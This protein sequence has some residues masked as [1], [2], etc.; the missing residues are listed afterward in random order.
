[1]DIDERLLAEFGLLHSYSTDVIYRLRYDNMSYEYISSSATKLLGFDPHE[2]QDVGIRSLI[3]QTRMIGDNMRRVSDNYEQLEQ[4]R[5]ERNVYKWQADYEMRTKDGRKIWVSDIS[6]PWFDEN[7][8]MIG[9][10][11]TLRDVT[12]RVKAEEAARASTAKRFFEDETTGLDARPAFF[13]KLEAEIRRSKRSKNEVTVMLMSVD[14]LHETLEQ[15][16]EELKESLI[17]DIGAIIHD[18]LRTTDVAAR[19]ADDGFAAVLPETKVADAFNAAERI[20]Q[21]ISEHRKE[22]YDGSKV[23]GDVSLGIAG[24]CFDTFSD[25]KDLFRTAEERL[26]NCREGIMSDKVAN[27]N[28]D[29]EVAAQSS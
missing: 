28:V 11:G 2:L 9:S 6:H 8:A 19:I 13:D 25:A 1:M 27:D 15:Y 23:R 7:G 20:R 10:I 26:K 16:G 21:R 12:D 5:L 24:S 14:N 22:T 17:K 4:Q 3:L 29:E 18:A